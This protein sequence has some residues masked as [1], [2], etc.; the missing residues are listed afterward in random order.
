MGHG[1]L[2]VQLAM[3]HN[4]CGIRVENRNGQFVVEDYHIEP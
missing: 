1:H 3:H 2:S 4:Q